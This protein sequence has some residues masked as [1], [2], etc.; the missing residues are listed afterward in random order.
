LR[1]LGTRT[2]PPTLREFSAANI[3]PYA[4]LSHTWG[5]E[6]ILF[7][8]I[9]NDTLASKKG[10]RISK[11]GD[12]WLSKKGA[13]K[14][15]GCCAEAARRG[16]DWVWIDTCCID[17]S[18]SAELTEAINSMFPWYRDAE[19]CYAFLDDLQSSDPID[20]IRRCRWIT[21]GWTL[22][23]LI[24]PRNVEFYDAEWNRCGSK[25]EH[26]VLLSEVT[27]IPS[28]LLRGATSIRSFSVATR[29]SWAAK[30]QT[31]RI[32][33]LAYCLLGIF[34]INMPPLYGEGSKAFLRL[35]EEIL[36]RNND[37]TIFAWR[38][39]SNKPPVFEQDFT[40]IF[41]ESLASF[42]HSSS[43]DGIS[44]DF[45]SIAITNKGVLFSGGAPLRVVRAIQPP[46]QAQ[47]YMLCLGNRSISGSTFMD[48]IILTK[49]DPNVFYRCGMGRLPHA[50]ARR[51]PAGWQGIQM[52]REEAQ[53]I[54][55]T[56]FYVLSTSKNPRLL[57]ANYRQMGIHVLTTPLLPSRRPY[58]MR[59]G[60]SPIG[61]SSG[62]NLTAGTTQSLKFLVSGSNI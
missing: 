25:E 9:G 47:Q 4:I 39:E 36:H 54:F 6:E 15:V 22:Q 24:A 38:Q 57:A 8:D 1:L 14:V 21:R 40:S 46:G 51:A 55:D 61:F 60:M 53:P 52:F 17:K 50:D 59:C 7:H 32:E 49:I 56:D 34:D 13:A 11:K 62:P 2:Q 28:K 10:I 44:G 33:D 58:H 12:S 42:R 23:E 41:A 37:M 29:L 5:E 3:P 45:G 19:V 43:L 27:G 18:S 26:S 20:E 35:Q 48:G 31:T 16:F 30:R